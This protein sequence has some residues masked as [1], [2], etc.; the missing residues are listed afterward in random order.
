PL[1]AD[2]HGA[3]EALRLAGAQREE[4]VEE[5]LLAAEK[6]ALRP[7][8]RVGH[9]LGGL[10]GV[11]D[12]GEI[13]ALVARVVSEDVLERDGPALE[14]GEVAV[15]ALKAENRRGVR[16][17]RKIRLGEALQVDGH[18]ERLS[19]NGSGKREG[20]FRISREHG[21]GMDLPAI[22]ASRES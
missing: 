14:I 11:L 9:G 3:A 22:S 13:D 18:R 20:A 10:I 17:D 7:E 2:R 5:P 21:S 16:I 12:G 4:I 1:G 8:K 15:G 6:I 19:G